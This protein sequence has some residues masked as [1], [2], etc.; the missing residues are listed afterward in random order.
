MVA[1]RLVPLHNLISFHII[2]NK[3]D[4]GRQTLFISTWGAENFSAQQLVLIKNIQKN[5]DWSDFGLPES[6]Q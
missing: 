4:R 3:K 5:I 6:T 1:E 2:Y